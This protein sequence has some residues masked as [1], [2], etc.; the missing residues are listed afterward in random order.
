M[1]GVAKN[2]NVSRFDE[3]VLDVAKVHRQGR[4]NQRKTCSHH[5]L[6]GDRER[7]HRQLAE[8]SADADTRSGTPRGSPA[9]RESAPCSTARSQSAGLPPGN[10]T[11][12]IRLPP[13]I[14]TFDDSAS[15]DENQ[16]QGRMPQNMKSAYGVTRSSCAAVHHVAEDE[17]V[18]QQQQQRIDEGPEEAEERSPISCF[19]L[20]RHQALNQSAV[21]D[22]RGEITE[23]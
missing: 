22:Q 6:D 14:R 19:E 12:L 23:H 18:D 5:Q 7:K 2:Q 15:D 20:P 17:G 11:F 3:D 8:M 13:E 16:V 21:A 10:S 4:Q 9:R 1:I